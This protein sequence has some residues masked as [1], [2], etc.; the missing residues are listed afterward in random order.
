MLRAL[1]KFT[2]VLEKVFLCKKHLSLISCSSTC[3]RS[4]FSFVVGSAATVQMGGEWSRTGGLSKIIIGRRWRPIALCS[5][6]IP[7][8]LAATPE[9]FWGRSFG[10]FGPARLGVILPKGAAIGAPFAG[11]FSTGPRLAF[12]SVC[13]IPYP[14]R[15]VW[16]PRW[17]MRGASKFTGMGM[18]LIG[19][20]NQAI[21]KSRGGWTTKIFARV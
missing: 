2:P 16:R 1:P 18:A 17:S 15:P 20:Q 4:G 12:L 14:Q 13:S 6:F 21:G 3:W 9:R 11:A 10:S 8:A 19:G 5:G 7:E